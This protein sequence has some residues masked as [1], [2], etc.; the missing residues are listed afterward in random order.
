MSATDSCPTHVRNKANYIA[1]KA[2][3]NARDLDLCLSYYAAEHQIMSRPTL[4]GR[5]HMRAFLDGTLAGWPDL[6]LEV[7]QVVA[8][9]DWVMGRAVV[10]ATHTTTV[11][12]RPPSGK[13]VVTTF[14]D[15][16]R[17][18]HAGLITQ[19][20][21]VMDGFALMEQLGLLPAP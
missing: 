21:N 8:E 5:E 19:T 16:H 14:W 20:W 13:P 2:A 4:P 11:M 7:T 10:N 18:D 6:W 12:G 3:F 1:A 15:L 17:F 9:G